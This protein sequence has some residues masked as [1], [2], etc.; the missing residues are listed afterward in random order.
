M[1][2]DKF[3]LMKQWTIGPWSRLAHITRYS[4]LPVL[5][6]ESVA[7][8]TF[9]VSIK[10]YLIGM[11]LLHGG[12]I[13]DFEA[14]LRHAIVHD[15]DEAFTG[16]IIRPFKYAN[17]NLKTL[18][19]QVTSESLRKNLENTPTGQ[20]MFSDW[21]TS[22]N[23]PSLE[24]N[25]VKVADLWSCVH[26]GYRELQLGNK[27][28]TNIMVDV[29][30]WVERHGWHDEIKPYSDGLIRLTRELEVKDGVQ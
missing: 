25:I 13:I 15:I 4:S 2:I 21:C 1:K 28:G 19:D 10:S 8:H 20:N 17:P 26:Y 30:Q 29:R 27:F 23:Y 14:V 3:H 18:M 11:D 16:D 12:V 5:H 9:F 6:R 24:H 7:E 22:S